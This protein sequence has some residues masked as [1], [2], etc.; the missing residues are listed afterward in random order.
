MFT[1]SGIRAPAVLLTWGLLAGCTDTT[2]PVGG[3]Y[4]PTLIEVSPS[5]FLGDI[6]CVDAPG[7]MRTYV[8]TVYDV[9]FDSTG[10]P[11]DYSM[12]E[13]GAAGA[14]GASGEPTGEGSVDTCPGL[15]ARGAGFPLPSS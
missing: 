2:V 12:P 7:A 4:H 1:R 14:G 11:I 3:V 5:E 10:A 6:P 15:A 9:E 13:E 8:A